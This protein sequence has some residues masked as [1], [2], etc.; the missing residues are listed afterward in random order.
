MIKK[1]TLLL[2]FSIVLFTNAF[3]QQWDTVANFNSYIMCLKSF[4]NKLF[5]GGDF[6]N[7]TNNTDDCYWSAYFVGNSLTPPHDCYTWVGN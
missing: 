7:S 1:I 3:A 5:I 2:S 4:N 6:T